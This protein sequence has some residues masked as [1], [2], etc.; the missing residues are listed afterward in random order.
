MDDLGRSMNYS[1]API[2]EAIIAIHFAGA[3]PVERREKL[4]KKLLSDFPSREHFFDLS[5]IVALGKEGEFSPPMGVRLRAVEK[6]FV[7]IISQS[8]FAIARVG[9]Y[10]NW[11]DLESEFLKQF[12]K[13]EKVLRPL[14]LSRVSTRFLNRIDIPAMSGTTVNLSDYFAA[15]LSIPSSLTLQGL[16]Q[17]NL[18]FTLSDQEQKIS[19]VVQ[20]ISMPDRPLIDHFSVKLDIDCVTDIMSRADIRQ[21]LSML[22]KTK[23]MIFEESLKQKA[24]DLFG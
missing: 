20:I 13:A 3:V 18:N 15:G 17:F 7:V 4:I 8:Q 2:E 24:K 11:D 1:K 16:A 5:Q 9:Q 6:P 21:S 22:R 23:N 14:Q 19:S 10:T 12:D